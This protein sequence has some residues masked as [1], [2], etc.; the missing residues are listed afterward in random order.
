MSSPPSVMVPTSR[1][2]AEVEGGLG[3]SFAEHDPVG[4]DVVEIVEHQPRDGDGFEIIDGVG[5]GKRSQP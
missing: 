1:V 2:G 3:A 5:A 4:F